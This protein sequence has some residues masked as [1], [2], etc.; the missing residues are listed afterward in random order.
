MTGATLISACGCCH[1]PVEEAEI[2]TLDARRLDRYYYGNVGFCR[3]CWSYLDNGW[4]VTQV[5]RKVLPA[6]ARRQR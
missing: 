3:H 6:G 1:G 4:S 5:R 2:G